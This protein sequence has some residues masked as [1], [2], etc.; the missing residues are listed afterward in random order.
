MKEKLI[1]KQEENR[2][3]I[4]HADLRKLKPMLNLANI[5]VHKTD[6]GKYTGKHRYYIDLYQGFKF[7]ETVRND[8]IVV[9]T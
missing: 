8:F 5:E 4:R 6:V 2:L 3:Y 9:F 7:L 1:V